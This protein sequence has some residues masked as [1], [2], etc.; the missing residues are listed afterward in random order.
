M[1]KNTLLIF[2]LLGCFVIQ[3][4]EINKPNFAVASHPMTVDNISIT[5]NQLIID[6]TIEN[7]V[8]GGNFCVDKNTHIENVLGKQK[9]LMMDSR[10]I[11]IC[12]DSYNFKW[13]GEKLKFQLIFQKPSENIKYLNIIENCNENCF[14]ILGLILNTEMNQQID[15][16]FEL[17]D[18]GDYKSSSTTLVKIINEYSDYP[19]GFLYLNLIQVLIIQEDFEKAKEYYNTVVNSA[20]YDKPYVLEQLNKLDLFK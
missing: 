3:A 12:P 13:I 15:H 8:N 14:S 1:K 11:P 5:S 19:F 18:K 17:F 7:K 10:N 9:F 20:Y 16:A 2:I 4:Q 6:F